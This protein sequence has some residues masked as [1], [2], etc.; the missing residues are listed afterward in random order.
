MSNIPKTSRTNKSNELLAK[1]KLK[2]IIQKELQK[3][4]PRDKSKTPDK[5]S[6]TENSANN[7]LDAI[8][9]RINNL[10]CISSNDPNSERKKELLLK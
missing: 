6:T 4:K 8:S 9:N 5:F 7:V 1:E 10:K 3:T 2:T